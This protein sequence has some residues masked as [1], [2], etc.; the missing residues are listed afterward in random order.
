MRKLKLRGRTRIEDPKLAND[1]IR[2]QG[3]SPQRLRFLGSAKW[4]TLLGRYA[5][6]LREGD[7]GR[8]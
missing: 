7:R 1:I 6:D 3:D 4:D 8:G 5:D 2:I